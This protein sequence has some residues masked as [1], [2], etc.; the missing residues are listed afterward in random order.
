MYTC[1]LIMKTVNVKRT[2]LSRTCHHAVD[3]RRAHAHITYRISF[4]TS[5]RS[6]GRLLFQIVFDNMEELQNRHANCLCRFVHPLLYMFYLLF[7][8][9]VVMRN[10]DQGY[11]TS[12]KPTVYDPVDIG[13]SLAS[14]QYVYKLQLNNQFI[15]QYN[16][17]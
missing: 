10:F 4:G 2:Q 13:S 15:M 17:N 9:K 12:S 8:M 16:S 7:I 11:A 14:L 5:S 1:T 3:F 6:D